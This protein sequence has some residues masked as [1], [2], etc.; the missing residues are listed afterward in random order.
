MHSIALLFP[1]IADEA[2]PAVEKVFPPSSDW[3]TVTTFPLISY[4]VARLAARIVVGPELCANDEWLNL[5]ITMVNTSMQ[6]ANALRGS[7]PSWARWASPYLFEPI[8]KVRAEQRRA[9]EILRPVL[10]ARRLAAT[11]GIANGD[12]KG[13]KEPR[14]P[15]FND[16]VQWLENYYR[17]RRRKLT[18]EELAQHEL[19]YAIATIHSSTMV[20]LSVLYDLIDERNKDAREVIIDEIEQTQSKYGTWTRAALGSLGKLDS[21]MKESQR[22]N[23]VGHARLT[24]VAKVGYTFKD[25]LYV[26]KGTMLQILHSGHQLDPEFYDEPLSFDPWRFLRKRQVAGD[27]NKFQFDSLSDIET[28]FGAG[29]HACPARNSATASIK[30]ILI[31]LITQYD[32]RFEGESQRRP[33]NIGHDHTTFPNPGIQIQYRLKAKSAVSKS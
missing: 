22:L 30:L 19:F 6:A 2:A 25:G 12:G 27:E 29:I 1:V 13:N 15:Q 4:A 10:E 14:V 8:K 28:Q 23:F 9:A 33:P 17:G 24:R 31:L 32:L 11:Q 16:A 18:L 26:P 7:W 20:A 3:V 5:C 21:F